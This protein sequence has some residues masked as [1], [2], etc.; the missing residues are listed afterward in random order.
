MGLFTSIFLIMMIPVVLIFII[1]SLLA[2]NELNKCNNREKEIER[3]LKDKNFN[4]TQIFTSDD[5]KWG[6]VY[7]GKN[8]IGILQYKN[9]EYIF[10]EIEA[11]NIIQS[12]IIEDGTTIM[13]TSRKNII[14]GAGIG[15]LLG[16]TAAGAVVGAISSNKKHVDEIKKLQ[17]Q[18]VV[19]DTSDPIKKVN[20]IDE[21]YTIKKSSSFFKLYYDKIKHWQKLIEVLIRN[22]EKENKIGNG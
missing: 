15:S 3:F 22:T 6:M 1:L 17:L 12:E 16:A 13:K 7:D 4:Y 19:N 5:K 14:V 8:K 18:I 9:N 11:K 21:N 20:F 2:K 10:E